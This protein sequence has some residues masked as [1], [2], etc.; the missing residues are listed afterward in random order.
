MSRKPPDKKRPSE[1]GL[2]GQI[3]A[4]A[5]RIRE[6]VIGRPRSDR[7][8]YA[9]LSPVF[10]VADVLYIVPNVIY[11]VILIGLFIITLPFQI[12]FYAWLWFSS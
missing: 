3:R 2:T 4:T 12:A 1:R 11:L 9:A 6:R 10:F 8:I 7:A 5:R